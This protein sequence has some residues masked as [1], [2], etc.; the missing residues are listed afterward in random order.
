MEGARMRRLVLAFLLLASP[1]LAQQPPLQD[2]P[3]TVASIRLNGLNS[4]LQACELD[5]H[6]LVRDF[7]NAQQE[8]DKLQAEVN[9]LTEKYEPKDK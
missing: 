5:S 1:A 6:R 4:L 7:K 9:R 3:L 2:D 8:R